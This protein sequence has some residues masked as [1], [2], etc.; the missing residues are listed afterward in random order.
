MC[1]QL[2][3]C[4]S[5]LAADASTTTNHHLVRNSQVLDSLVRDITRLLGPLLGSNSAAEASVKKVLASA[6]SQGTSLKRDVQQGAKTAAQAADELRVIVRTAFD[7][8]RGLLLSSGAAEASSNVAGVAAEAAAAI[9]DA[10]ARDRPAGALLQI[11]QLQVRLQACQKP[12][13]GL[14]LYPAH[15]PHRPQTNLGL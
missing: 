2:V 1:K 8:I 3:C 15:L 7:D 10:L 14:L 5:R 13:Q 11:G 12:G 6:I 9:S 4:A